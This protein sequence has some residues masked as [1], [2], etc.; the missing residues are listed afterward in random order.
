MQSLYEE[1]YTKKEIV[2]MLKT[3]YRRV[4]KNLNGDPE[5]LCISGHR[6]TIRISKLDSYKDIILQMITEG[7]QYKEMLNI[8]ISNG[9]SGGYSRFCEYCASIKGK[10]GNNSGRIKVHRVFMNRRD[11]FK[12]IWS[13]KDIN[14][15]DKKA[16]FEKH[17]ELIVIHDCVKAFREMYEQKNENMLLNFIEK[18]KNSSIKALSSFANG[19]NNDLAA[20][21][22]SVTSPYSNGILEGNNN[23]LKLIKRMMYGRA[24][25]PLL[26]AKVLAN[27]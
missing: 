2:T 27:T 24:K 26:R 11:I 20:V 7:K 5:N 1:G 4:R 9:Y 3:T 8:L 14:E 18:Y 23:R 15:N 13:N 25:L 10:T 6:N 12:H 16:V 17:P 21:K 22:N 19:L